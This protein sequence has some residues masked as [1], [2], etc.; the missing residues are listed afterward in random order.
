MGFLRKTVETRGNQYGTS[1]YGFDDLNFLKMLGIDAGDDNIDPRKLNEIT[2]Y[3]CLKTL[4]DKVSSLPIETFQKNAQ[5]RQKVD[6]YLNYLL[7]VQPNTYQNASTFWSTTE[8]NLCDYGNAYIYIQTNNKGKIANLWVLPSQAVQVWVDDAGV[9][10]GLPNAIW[11]LYTDIQSGKITKLQ[12][13]QVIHLKNW[14]TYLG[15]GLVGL[16]VKNILINYIEMGQYS[17][18]FLSDLVKGGMITDKICISYTGDMNKAAE[19]KLVS[20]LQ[21]F[22]QTSGNKWI[23]LPLGI[24]ATP[25]SSSLVDAQFFD[26]QKYNA[27]QI[28][29][30]F[31]LSP[32]FINNYDKGNYANI[33]TQQDSL[34]RDC[35][36]PVLTQYEQELQIKLLT[37]QEKA[38]GIYFKFNM[39]EILRGNFADRMNAYSVATNSG[40]LTRNECRAKE[41][42]SPIV[43]GDK[44][45]V[46][47]AMINIDQ[48]GEQYGVPTKN[49]TIVDGGG[50]SIG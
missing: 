9:M 20:K 2:Y 39:D 10:G 42:L 14:C 12:Y 5:G 40:I 50:D 43:G 11:Y 18:N 16:S 27:L 44:L 6:S 3:T 30:A 45:T 17:S 32:S 15:Q 36:L 13:S 28:A 7:A 26:F 8:F 4:S 48:V 35:L 37:P 29:G 34:Y 38:Q 41:D 23:P 46:N 22:S 49:Q 31:G 1:A 25:L 47:G 21:G 24:T 33:A 19:S